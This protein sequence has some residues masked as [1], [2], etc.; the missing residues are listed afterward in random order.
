[1][2]GFCEYCNEF[3]GSIL[4]LAEELLTA[5]R[6]FLL[7]VDFAYVQILFFSLDFVHQCQ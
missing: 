6:L 2:S 1:V 3:L 7:A 4:W 5:C